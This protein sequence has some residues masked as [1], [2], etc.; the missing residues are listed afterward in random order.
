M[1][2]ADAAVERPV[3]AEAAAAHRPSRRRPLNPPGL[4]PCGVWPARRGPEVN[5]GRRGG[6]PIF[7]TSSGNGRFSR[8]LIPTPT[9]AGSG[10]PPQ[11]ANPPRRPRTKMTMMGSQRPRSPPPTALW[12]TP[13][14]GRN[15]GSRL[16]PQ[17]TSLPI[18]TPPGP[19]GLCLCL[20]SPIHHRPH[21]E[22]AGAQTSER[23]KRSS[24]TAVKRGG[25]ARA[26]PTVP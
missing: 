4:C 13:T 14:P 15:H 2:R 3:R 10:D 17:T 6:A 23:A 5:A 18:T 22:R 26:I 11:A 8:W 25:L 7:R 12:P 16:R 19:A 1:W 9:G 24:N 21:P 20:C